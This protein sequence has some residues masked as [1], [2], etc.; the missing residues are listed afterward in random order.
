MDWEGKNS[1]AHAL[2]DKKTFWSQKVF[3]NH[4]ESAH[5]NAFLKSSQEDYE[6]KRVYGLFGHA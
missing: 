4:T 2:M 5:Q 1:I 6:Q 3:L